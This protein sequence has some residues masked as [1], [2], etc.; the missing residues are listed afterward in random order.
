MVRL[1][2]LILFSVLSA[3]FLSCSNQKKEQDLIAEQTVEIAEYKKIIRNNLSS[4]IELLASKP[5]STILKELIHPY[6]GF[7]YV[8]TPGLYMNIQFYD[9]TDFLNVAEI[10][11]SGKINYTKRFPRN[12][13]CNGGYS[14]L[15]N[16][17][18]TEY[19]STRILNAIKQQVSEGEF[20]FED[21]DEL[22]KKYDFECVTVSQIIDPYFE[23]T[24]YFSY[25]DGQ[26][27][28]TGMETYH[29]CSA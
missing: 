7:A 14:S 24:Y 21:E 18:D 12:K 27:Y 4:T 17:C 25:F 2:T 1:K 22:L 19:S 10:E 9:T 11:L 3:F 28:L 16:Y 20:P 15:G 23:K 5:D 26:W 6:Y 29:I 13:G 8:S